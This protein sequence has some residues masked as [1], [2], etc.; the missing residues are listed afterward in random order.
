MSGALGRTNVPKENSSLPLDG[1]WVLSRSVPNSLNNG[2]ISLQRWSSSSPSSPD[3]V[4]ILYLFRV[5]LVKT[6]TSF[7]VVDYALA[8]VIMFL[9]FFKNEPL[10]V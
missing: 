6:I 4:C 1:N 10:L 8:I 9:F 2:N 3:Q 5:L 7:E